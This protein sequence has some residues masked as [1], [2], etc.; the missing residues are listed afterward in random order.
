MRIQPQSILP[1]LISGF[2][3][4]AV[5][6]GSLAA[7]ETTEGTESQTTEQDHKQAADAE[8]SQPVQMVR[9]M[10]NQ[11][12]VVGQLVDE[13]EGAITV[14]APGR[15]TITYEKSR[16]DELKRFTIGRA[17]YFEKLGDYFAGQVWDF[18]N[19]EQDF[20]RAQ[21][22]YL[23]GMTQAPEGGLKER[24]KRK[25][26]GVEKQRREWQEEAL[27]REELRHA[28]EKT[29]KAELEKELAQKKLNELE[30][31]LSAVERL[32]S[33][34]RGLRKKLAHIE[35]KINAVEGFAGKNRR[36]I[37]R[38][39]DTQEWL[40]EEIDDLEDDLHDHHDHRYRH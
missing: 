13:K 7:Q 12:Q 20:A 40:E 9:F 28:E 2:V 33:G 17:A 26:Q 10:L 4:L 19:D 3:V 24:L 29:Q 11:K 5:S 22:Y 6:S 32:Q 34:Y 14:R 27:R 31:A 16:I 39:R 1:C 15:G 38:L 21:K 30:G 37:H 36:L 23:Q 18:Q 25:Y 8:P 35:D